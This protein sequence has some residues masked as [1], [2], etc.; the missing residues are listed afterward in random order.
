MM[1]IRLFF[2]LLFASLYA[3]AQVDD[4]QLDL[5]SIKNIKTTRYSSINEVG[6]SISVSGDSIYRFPDNKVK[7]HASTDRPSVILRTVHGALINP[8]F[9]IGGGVG[10]DFT[11]TGNFGNAAV[12]S[13]YYVTF[14]LFV[15]LREYILD[16]NFNIFFSERMG[17]AFFID[18]QLNK[19]SHKGTSSGAFGEFMIGG[20]YVTQ[21]KKL[22][23][24]FGLG[25]RFQ[26]LQ[27]KSDVVDF[28][29]TGSGQIY[30]TT[31]NT[32]VISIKHYVPITIGVTF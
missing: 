18:P 5:D 15:E 3:A 20:R 21:G 22:A 31:A 7:R 10:L 25:Y 9:F 26:H 8:D 29:K 19:Y 6:I 28:T 23:L 1:K 24:H 30:S 12:V 4:I 11:P 27:R 13:K 16:G 14:P 2:L 17:A 32:P